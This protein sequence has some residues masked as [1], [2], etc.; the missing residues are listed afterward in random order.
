MAHNKAVITRLHVAQLEKVLH[1]NNAGLVFVESNDWVEAG[2]AESGGVW[3][4][5]GR[6]PGIVTMRSLPPQ[7]LKLPISKSCCHCC[8]VSVD[9]G[10]CRSCSKCRCARYCSRE[11]QRN[12]WPEHQKVCELLLKRSTTYRFLQT[13]LQKENDFPADATLEKVAC[14][15]AAGHTAVHRRAAWMLRCR[16]SDVGSLSC[17]CNSP[18]RGED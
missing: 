18:E 11:C 14:A 13:T 5:M 9:C 2:R 8:G 17:H 12:H 6:L 3:Q 7:M 4:E 10:H 16:D 15:Q 1:P